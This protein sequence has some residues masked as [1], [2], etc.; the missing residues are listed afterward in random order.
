MQKLIAKIARA[1][2]RNAHWTAAEIIARE[3]GTDAE[4]RVLSS[5]ALAHHER[6]FILDHELAARTA[7]T[8]AILGRLPAQIA[9]TINEAL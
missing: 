5:Y 9:N 8:N 2:D 3:W 1:T 6:G 4:Q 7:I